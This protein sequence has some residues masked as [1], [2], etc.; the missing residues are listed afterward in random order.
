MDTKIQKNQHVNKKP[1]FEKIYRELAA[2]KKVSKPL[3]GLF[4]KQ[5]EWN[6][7]DVINANKYLFEKSSDEVMKFN[8][9]HRSYDESSIRE[10]L[11]YQ[12]ENELNIAQLMREFNIS[13]TTIAKWQKLFK[14]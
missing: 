2:K 4:N 1:D 13:R 3:A 14:E 7:L 10:I 8:Q 11:Q 12:K 5:K 6:S 9:R